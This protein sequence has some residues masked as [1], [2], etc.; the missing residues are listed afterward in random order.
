VSDHTVLVVDDDESVFKALRRL[1]RQESYELIY[2]ADGY[3][4]LELLTSNNIDLVIS[5]LK[6]PAMDGVTFLSQVSTL[7]P[8]LPSILL[9]GNADLPEIVD[10]INLGQ[11]SYF[12]QKPWNGEALKLTVREFLERRELQQAQ[13][14]LTQKISLQNE[15][16]NKLNLELQQRQEELASKSEALAQQVEFRSRLIALLSHEIRTPLNGIMGMLQLMKE[17]DSRAAVGLDAAEDLKRILDDVLDYFKL[18]ADKMGLEEAQF[19]PADLFESVVSLF[20]NEATE[21]NL[22]LS[23]QLASDLPVLLQGDP[24]RVRQVLSNLLS[25]AL[26]YTIVGEIKI[27]VTWQADTNNLTF[28][29]IDSGSGITPEQMPLLFEEFRLLDDSHARLFGGTGLGLSICKRLVDLMSGDIEV[30]S[31]PGV[32]SCFQVRLPLKSVAA[33]H[34]KDVDSHAAS[35][36]PGVTVM[37]VDD[38]EINQM[39][40]KAMLERQG[41]SV[42]TFSS[43]VEALE[44]LG[45]VSKPDL[46][47]TDISMPGMDGITFANRIRSTPGLEMIPVVAMT[48][49]SLDLKSPDL[50]VMDGYVSKP[51]N[52]EVLINEIRRLTEELM[53]DDSESIVINPKPAGSVIDD[54][55]FLALTREIDPSI[56]Q[57]LLTVFCDDTANRSA[58]IAAAVESGSVDTLQ[59]EVHTLGSSAGQFGAVALQQ[60]CRAVEEMLKNGHKDQALQLAASIRANAAAVILAMEK[61]DLSADSTLNV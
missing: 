16:L 13:K 24:G 47:L 59:A 11:I 28:E 45:G 29:V 38:H 9:T 57:K 7:Y 5:D 2:A 27:S 4:G 61:V 35:I 48:A 33:T 60:Q 49:H 34:V 50:K 3:H 56:L 58:T 10:A 14:T 19:N 53:S 37:V 31:E 40:V 43:A 54:G 42:I 15:E 55:V 18:D 46:I 1:L 39:V 41:A 8:D 32:G 25:N 23:L 22:L 44:A 52:Q 21:K 51:V 20:A 17:G 6:M 12:L 30:S 26:K 36:Q